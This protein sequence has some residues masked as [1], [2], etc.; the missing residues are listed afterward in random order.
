MRI[1][2]VFAWLTAVLAV[3][4]GCPPANV[5]PLY[6]VTNKP[7]QGSPQQDLARTQANVRR[8]AE[9]AGWVVEEREP[10]EI[11]ATKRKGQHGATVSIRFDTTHFTIDYRSSIRL[12]YA[13]A[14]EARAEPPAARGPIGGRSSGGLKKRPSTG[15]RH[16]GSV[17]RI[18]K[19]YNRWVKELESAVQQEAVAG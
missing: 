16:P 5:E 7:L 6:R 14:T 10:G 2:L 17:E 15:T 8:A 12:D 13:A 9:M 4:A 19:L 1:V 3:A 18:H 11:L